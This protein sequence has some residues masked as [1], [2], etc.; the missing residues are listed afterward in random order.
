MKKF[1]LIVAMLCVT[2]GAYAQKYSFTVYAEPQVTWLSPDS[3]NL[4]SDGSMIGFNGG[5]NFDNFFTDNYAFSTGI[6]IN[7]VNGRLKYAEGGN[8]QGLDSLYSVE[9]GEVAEYRLQYIN[10][11]IGL[12]FQ[13]VE[14]GYTRFYAHLGLDTYVNIKSKANL[15]HEENIDIEEEVQWY[16][17]GYYI[18]GGIEYSL[19]GT[20]ALVAGI[21]YNNGFTDITVATDEKVTTG[22]FSL[23][24][25]IKF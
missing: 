13:T 21:A 11:P 9:S 17:L 5:L 14:I 2:L 16:N 23:R 6:S 4:D 3:R 24:L 1:F 12:K 10:I 25:G 18:G 22:T 19:G 15:Q 8:L 20:T 7:N